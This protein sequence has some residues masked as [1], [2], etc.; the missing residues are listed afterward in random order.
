MTEFCPCGKRWTEFAEFFS[1][2]WMFSASAKVSPALESAS[3]KPSFLQQS[4][5]SRDTSLDLPG[6]DAARAQRRAS[7]GVSLPDFARNHFLGKEK[8]RL[9]AQRMNVFHKRVAGGR[10]DVWW[11]YDDGGLTLL[12]PHLLR[13]PKSYLEVGS[14]PRHPTAALC[15]ARSCA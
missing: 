8:Q 9:L 10:I 12:L 14:R 2:R 11:L 6:G 7:D 1:D 13:L 4:F 15:R 3:R 5:Q